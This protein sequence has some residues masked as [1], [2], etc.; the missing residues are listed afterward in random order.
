MTPSALLADLYRQGITLRVNGDRLAVKAPDGVLKPGLRS[1]MIKHKPEL[2][3]L[4]TL[5]DE[6]RK[7]LCDGFNL[8]L[9]TSGPTDAECQKFTDDQVRLTDE[10]GPTL[11]ATIHL[12]TGREWRTQTNVC[13]WC[14]EDGDC[15]EPSAGGPVSGS[16]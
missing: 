16:H 6:Y 15:H 7:V 8:L 11:A 12:T 13:P 14:D 2:L 3:Q 9:R 5:V 4:V 10:L 1:A